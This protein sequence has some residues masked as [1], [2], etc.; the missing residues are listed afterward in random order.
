MSVPQD[1]NDFITSRRPAA[2]CN[3]CVA[4]GVGLTNDT[5]HPAQVTAAL[6]TTTDFVREAGTC[7]MCKN[8]KTVIRRA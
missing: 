8:D 7:S 4:E 2:F 3:K 1:I 6:G 5:A